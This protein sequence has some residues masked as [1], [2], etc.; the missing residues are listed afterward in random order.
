MSSG[1]IPWEQIPQQPTKNEP[2]NEH[3][4]THGDVTLDVH[5]LIH[6]TERFPVVKLPLTP[7]LPQLKEPCWH[8]DH[9]REIA[10]HTIINLIANYGYGRAATDYPEFAQ[11]ISRIE[12]ADR[13]YPIHI[14]QGAIINGM[15]RL[16]QLAVERQQGNSQNFITAKELR[17]L[18]NEAII[19]TDQK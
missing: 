5:A 13:R 16:A 3:T 15:H 11:H 17:T 8:D 6:H 19:S 4:S 12:Q 10:P 18:P 1:R 7:L 2:G 14:Y 9:G